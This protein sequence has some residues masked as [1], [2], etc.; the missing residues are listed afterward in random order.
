[1]W[2][3]RELKSQRA[4]FPYP[5]PAGLFRT[6]V[7]HPANLGPVCTSV[8]HPLSNCNLLWYSVHINFVFF[9]CNEPIWL[10]H[11]QKKKSW[12][13]GGSRKIEDSMERW[14]ASP[15]WPTYI[16][17]K[18][19]TLCKKHMG[20]K[21]GA[22]GNT[23]GNM[24]GTKKKWKKKRNQSTLSAC[25]AFPLAAWNFYFQNWTFVSLV[26]VSGSGRWGGRQPQEIVGTHSNN[27]EW[28]LEFFA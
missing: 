28:V 1:M 5:M 21:Q 2:C 13:Y 27:N 3:C 26:S 8:P 12:N 19:R 9:F 20:L 18:G 17:E 11:S 7:C 4:G 16:G 23:L 25:W 22:I 24:L 10:T 14:S 6:F 15:L